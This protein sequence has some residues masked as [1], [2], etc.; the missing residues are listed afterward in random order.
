MTTTTTIK[1]STHAMGVAPVSAITV[2]PGREIPLWRELFSGVDWLAL[3][4]SPIYFGLGERRGDGSPVVV[5][6][7]LF[8]TDDYLLSSTLGFGGSDTRHIS[9]T[10][11]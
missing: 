2:E 4:L 6:P 3:R 5:V 8:G 9:P 7:G 1:N 11:A 10:S